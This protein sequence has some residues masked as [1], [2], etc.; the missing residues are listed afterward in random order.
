MIQ[1]GSSNEIKSDSLLQKSLLEANHLTSQSAG[2]CHQAPEEK[3]C[4]SESM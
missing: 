4:H 2:C 1:Q 3:G